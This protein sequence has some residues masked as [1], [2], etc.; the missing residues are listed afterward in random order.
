MRDFRRKKEVT[1]LNKISEKDIDREMKA[2]FR[3]DNLIPKIKKTYKKDVNFIE[4]KGINV[5]V[6]LISIAFIILLLVFSIPI[7]PETVLEV[8]D[9]EVFSEE[10]DI[11]ETI[12]KR[13]SFGEYMLNMENYDEDIISITGHLKRYRLQKDNGVVFLEVLSDDLGN[14]IELKEIG[15]YNI[16]MPELGMTTEAFTVSGEFER[17]YNRPVIYVNSISPSQMEY[18]NITIS[19]E[20]VPREKVIR[21]EVVEPRKSIMKLLVGMI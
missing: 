3:R 4:N 12:P 21:R 15:D 6:F 13:I 8:Y 9:K 19:K 17:N 18:I 16:F 14:E 20:I 11:V 7:I 10:I 2:I 1:N 5:R